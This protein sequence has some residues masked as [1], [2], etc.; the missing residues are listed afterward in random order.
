MPVGPLDG[1][2]Q[3]PQDRQHHGLTEMT[4]E[5]FVYASDP[6]ILAHAYQLAGY[7]VTVEDSGLVV[8]YTAYGETDRL[9]VRQIAAGHGAD[10][11]GGGMYVGALP[12]AVAPQ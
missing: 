3:A 9:K 11:A 10:Y 7:P 4:Y 12:R 6:K 1:L 2:A 5:H 8:V